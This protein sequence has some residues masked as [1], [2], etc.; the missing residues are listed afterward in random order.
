MYIANYNLAVLLA[1]DA[2]A[3]SCTAIPACFT[4]F[5]K[6]IFLKR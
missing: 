1:K 6:A 4:A 3:F 5:K 2:H